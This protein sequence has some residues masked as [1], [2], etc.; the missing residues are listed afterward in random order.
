M[1]KAVPAAR[2]LKKARRPRE[3]EKTGDSAAAARD[4]GE[5]E[6]QVSQKGLGGTGRTEEPALA[7]GDSKEREK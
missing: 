1:A 5:K 4:P 3:I 2:G 6:K 7:A